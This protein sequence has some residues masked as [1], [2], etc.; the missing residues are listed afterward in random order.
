MSGK[1]FIKFLTH[2][3]LIL[4][5]MVFAPKALIPTVLIAIWAYL[6]EIAVNTSG[7][8]TSITAKEFEEMPNKR[9]EKYDSVRRWM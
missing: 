8:R 1:Q 7:M 4:V 9:V 5:A 6:V 3:V 2:V